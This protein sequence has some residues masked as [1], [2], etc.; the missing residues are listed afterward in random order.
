VKQYQTVLTTILIALIPVLIFA[1]FLYRHAAEVP[2]TDVVELM[3]L[4]KGCRETEER[5]P[6]ELMRIVELQRSYYHLVSQ[7]AIACKVPYRVSMDEEQFRK[8]AFSEE[9]REQWRPMYVGCCTY[10]YHGHYAVVAA[11]NLG[12]EGAIVV[13]V[14]MVRA[15]RDYFALFK[16]R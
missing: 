10:S 15:K 8:Q 1:L 9:I 14:A 2:T 13:Q 5:P 6:A 3:P 16:R 11:E 7:K 4:P 12:R